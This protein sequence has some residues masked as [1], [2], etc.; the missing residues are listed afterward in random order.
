MNKKTAPGANKRTIW[1][2]ALG[3]LI[4][5]LILGAVAMLIA[6]AFS[7][8]EEEAPPLPQPSE[9]VGRSAKDGPKLSGDVFTTIKKFSL[10]DPEGNTV[11]KA[12]EIGGF[13]DLD[14]FGDK[15]VVRMP[16]GRAKDVEVL[17]RRGPSGR[18]SLSEAFR[19][20][21][22]PHTPK[23]EKGGTPL[24]IGPLQVTNVKMTVA[25]GK[26]P[27]VIHIDRATVRIQ[28]KVSDLA[29]RVF[30]SNVHGNLL[31]P[32]PLPQ[33]IAIEGAEGVIDL[34]GDPL[35]DLRARVCI[36]DSEMRVRIEMPERN[37]QVR[38]TMDA[39]GAMATTASAALNV[40]SMFKS[41]KLAVGNG[42]VKVEEPFACARSKGQEKREEIDDDEARGKN[43]A[44]P[45]TPSSENKPAKTP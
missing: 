1:L 45:G 6:P 23:Q 14:S 13:L 35:V 16:R 40:V 15:N 20:N 12:A 30:L 36:G 29:P 11:L 8:G 7:G 3:S 33:P 42:S 2:I 39:H 22:E 4:G 43:E 32:D 10:E 5:G 18:V 31:S 44:T 38:M 26:S 41:D 17:L 9:D 34:A 19:G 21:S 37:E 27:I 25:M 28:R 24:Q